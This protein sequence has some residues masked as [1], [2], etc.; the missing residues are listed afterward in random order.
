V[1]TRRSSGGVACSIG[2]FSRLNQAMG[3]VVSS[4]FLVLS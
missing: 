2:L 3:K 4:Q 1:R